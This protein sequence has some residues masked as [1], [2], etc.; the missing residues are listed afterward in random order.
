M[1]ILMVKNHNHVACSFFRWTKHD[2]LF[3]SVLVD[4]EVEE[5]V[6]WWENQWK[7]L[8]LVKNSENQ[9]GI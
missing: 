4:I 6:V 1:C 8:N 9:D 7:A 5:G 3:F 2:L